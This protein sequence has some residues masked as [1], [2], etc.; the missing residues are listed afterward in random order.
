MTE[1]QSNEPLTHPAS[2][3]FEEAFTRLGAMVETL[4]AGNLPLDQAAQMFEQGMML[5]RRCTQLLD[6][7]ELRIAE[8]RENGGA[9]ATAQ[10][11]SL[12][13]GDLEM[14]P[15]DEE[16]EPEEDLPDGD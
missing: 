9:P 15:L 7:T 14:P 1:P 13:W 4:E 10:Q 2:L 3:T 8:I 5:V 11:D 6:E 16:W 12:S